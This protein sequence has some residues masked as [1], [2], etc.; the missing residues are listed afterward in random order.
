[1]T[2]A[3]TYCTN[4]LKEAG[5]LGVG[6]TA[7]AED[8]ND[9][10]TRLQG[11]L[12]Q[13]QKKR[14]LVPS[15]QLLAM[16]WNGAKSNSVC[17]GGYF[18]TPR[19]SDIKGAYVVQLNTGSTPVSL[20]LSKIFSFEDYIRITVKDLNSLPDHFFYDNQFPTA[21]LYI[22]PIGNS[23]YEIHILIQSQ[24][25]FGTTIYKG[26]ILTQGALYTDGIYPNVALSG[27]SGIGATADITV[28]AGKVAIVTLDTGG[29]DYAVG[30]ILSADASAV[31]GT[32]AGFTWQV[33]DIT[34]NLDTEIEL[35][36]EYDEAIHYNLTI[37]TC[38][39]Y[40]VQPMPDTKRLAKASLNTI[41]VV[42]TQIPALIMPNIPGLR[43]GRA[44]N[45]W[46]ADGY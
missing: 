28:T 5:I 41:K 23:Q 31:G 20:P 13:W 29:Q 3:R 25:G 9:V 4:A 8:I 16:P 12:Y 39:L 14:W 37:R 10:F 21:N 34:A 46:N 42:N 11:M 7:L 45:I 27:G 38:S 19:P 44:F 22:W 24:L 30:D 1:M 40:Q 35:P 36:P 17:T 18:N 43:Q 6:Q 33:T 15:L 26:I 2:N 32:G